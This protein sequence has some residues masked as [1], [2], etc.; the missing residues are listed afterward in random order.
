MQAVGV[1]NRQ[2]LADIAEDGTVI[3]REMPN[4]QQLD[5]IKRALGEMGAEAVDQ[6][7][8]RTG[9]GNRA[10]DLARSL[11]A[12]LVDAVPEYG[13]AVRLGGD[14]IERDLALRLG[15]D[16]LKPGTTREMVAE[17]FDG[18]SQEARTAAMQGLRSSID[19]TLANVKRAVGSGNMEAREA[20]LLLRNMSSRANREKVAMLLGDEQAARLFAELDQATTAFELRAATATNS[21]TFAR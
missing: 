20:G 3:F 19:D 8:R 6:F 10:A 11:K 7:G 5:Y 4:V 17:A 12:A 9:E 2:I 21:K 16:L 14:K 15:G 1:R 18:M 13:A